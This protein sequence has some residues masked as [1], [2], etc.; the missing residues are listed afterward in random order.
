MKQLEIGQAARRCRPD[1]HGKV[2][3]RKFTSRDRTALPQKDICGKGSS[4]QFVRPEPYRIELKMAI[5]L[6]R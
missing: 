3:F 6:A 2:K 1:A 5:Y 4:A